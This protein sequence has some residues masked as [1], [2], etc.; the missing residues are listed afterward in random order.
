MIWS[1]YPSIAINPSIVFLH[2]SSSKTFTIQCIGRILRLHPNKKIA[3]VYLPCITENNTQNTIKF[4]KQITDYDEKFKKDYNNKTLGHYINFENCL[5]YEENDDDDQH[6]IKNQEIFHKYDMV[7]NSFGVDNRIEL[8]LEFVNNENRHP[9]QT[10]EYQGV[11]IGSFWDCIKQGRNNNLYEQYLESNDILRINYEKTQKIKEEKEGIEE[12][13]PHQKC[14][15]LLEFVDLNKKHPK[16]TEEYQ[17]VKIGGFWG[18]IKQGHNANLYEQHLKNN[19]ILRI[20]YD[21][22][23]KIKE[24][25]RR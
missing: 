1:L 15:I 6:E 25:K 24:D 14:L 2:L 12:K 16:K 13:T 19:D 11:K 7:F 8:L 21:K 9:K 23:Q 20:A 10:E 4:I 22:A 17:G 5:K 3:N 18:S